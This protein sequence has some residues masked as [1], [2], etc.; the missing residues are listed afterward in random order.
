MNLG[1]LLDPTDVSY[2]LDLFDQDRKTFPYFWRDYGHHQQA[3]YDA[4]IT[5]QKFDELIRHPK[6]MP[7]IER[8]MGGPTLL[9][10]Q[11]KQS[12]ALKWSAESN[13]EIAHAH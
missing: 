11:A 5:T 3:N 12:F 2:F 4:L 10:S 7:T 8:L 1:Q 9:V 13:V 6:L